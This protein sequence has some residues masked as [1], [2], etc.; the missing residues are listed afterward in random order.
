MDLKKADFDWT[1]DKIVVQTGT[2]ENLL[3]LSRKDKEAYRI[4]VSLLDHDFI[5]YMHKRKQSF[6]IKRTKVATIWQRKDLLQRGDTF[7]AVSDPVKVNKSAQNRLVVIFSSMPPAED[8]YSDNVASRMFVKNYPSMPKHLIKNVHILRIMDLNRS[9]G[10]YY[11]NAGSY[12]TFEEDV[13]NIITKTCEN[14][15]ISKEDVVLY[16]ASKGGTGALYHSILGNYHAVVVDPIFSITQYN[17]NNDIHYLKNVLPEKLLSK[18]QQALLDNSTDRKKVILG[19]SGVPENYSEYSQ[20][21]DPSF[22]IVN[23]KDSAMV[24]HVRISPNCNAEQIT[25][26]NA[27]LMGLRL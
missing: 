1:A 19:T 14:Y 20:I 12:S 13:Q 9:S 4:Y 23:M 15:Q 17:N 6:F 21:E 11:L 8:Y 5:L 24:D 10:S 18:F 26:I 27:F 3:K 7:Y 25:F 16:G 2:D 22:K